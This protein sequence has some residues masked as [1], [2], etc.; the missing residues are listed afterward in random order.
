MISG[1]LNELFKKVNI[2]LV[3]IFNKVGLRESHF[4]YIRV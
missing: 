2:I 1:I 3:Y 4:E